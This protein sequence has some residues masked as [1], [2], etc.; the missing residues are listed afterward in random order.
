MKNPYHSINHWK[1]LEAWYGPSSICRGNKSWKSCITSFPKKK[2]PSRSF[3][4]PLRPMTSSV[5]VGVVRPFSTSLG[6]ILLSED[7]EHSNDVPDF[8]R[9][10]SLSKV[11]LFDKKNVHVHHNISHTSSHPSWFNNNWNTCI[12]PSLKNHLPTS[13]VSGDSHHHR[14]SVLSNGASHE[15]LSNS[16]GS[17]GRKCLWASKSLCTCRWREEKKMMK[18]F[19]PGSRTQKFKQTS[20]DDL[21]KNDLPWQIFWVEKLTD[22][23]W[24][25]DLFFG[26]ESATHQ[27]LCP[28]ARV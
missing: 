18:I 20:P 26:S 23:F 21:K 3:G 10:F 6:T 25:A 4:H 17:W 13:E 8:I 24:F 28:I 27:Q 11:F 2:M 15:E 9:N 5:C 12:L 7:S 16:K 1:A 14:A 22:L 19:R